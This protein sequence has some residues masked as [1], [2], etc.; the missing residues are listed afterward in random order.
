MSTYILDGLQ[1]QTNTQGSVAALDEAGLTEADLDDLV[2]TALH[3]ARALS[4]HEQ[5][6][7]LS[8]LHC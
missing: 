6:R 3:R 2:S 5:T 8:V 1:Q 4:L 7:L